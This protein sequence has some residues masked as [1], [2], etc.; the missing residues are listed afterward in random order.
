MPGTRYVV[1]S[2]GTSKPWTLGLERAAAHIAPTTPLPWPT[3]ACLD[4]A[5]R[6]DYSVDVEQL[7]KLAR[8]ATKLGRLAGFAGIS[9]PPGTFCITQCP[10][11]G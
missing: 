3:P 11:T 4:G 10:E 7:D 8:E 9:P 6:L 2:A 1:R 5:D